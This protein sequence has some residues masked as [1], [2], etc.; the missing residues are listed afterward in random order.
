[1]CDFKQASVEQRLELDEE[2]RLSPA[3]DMN[4]DRGEIALTPGLGIE[5]ERRKPTIG[6]NF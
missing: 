4:R 5:Y 3:F 2:A 6:F 1:M